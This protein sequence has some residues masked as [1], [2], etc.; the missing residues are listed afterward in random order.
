M[1]RIADQIR[2]APDLH[3]EA[4]EVVEWGVKLELRSMSARQRAAFA[5]EMQVNDDGSPGINLGRIEHLWSHVIQGA[6]FDPDTGEAVFTD[7]D[8]EWLMTEKNAAVVE[9]L[10]T[11]CLEVS[12]MTA[13]A[14]DEAGKD[15]SGSPTPEV[16]E[17]LSDASTSD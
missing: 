11:R 15:S 4:Y 13:E 16:D 12:G 1:S 5:T 8:L 17:P 6:C 2:K 3:T 9:A 7:D 10:A 14:V